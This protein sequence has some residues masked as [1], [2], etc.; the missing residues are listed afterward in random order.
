MSAVTGKVSSHVTLTICTSNDC[1]D[2][3]SSR[4]NS[5]T[6]S[7]CDGAIGAF[8]DQ[9]A[10]V[11]VG[12]R[13]RRRRRQHEVEK[14][15]HPPS[16]ES[17]VSIAENAFGDGRGDTNFKSP[18]SLRTPA[19]IQMKQLGNNKHFIQYRQQ[20]CLVASIGQLLS[21]AYS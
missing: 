8:T 3:D 5:N 13:R 16:L 1:A 10:M 17:R 19:G 4:S 11:V 7:G 12:P 14:L 9:G 15:L 18:S 6:S 2:S 21:N 20:A